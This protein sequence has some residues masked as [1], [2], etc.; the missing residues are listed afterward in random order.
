MPPGASGLLIS[1]ARNCPPCPVLYIIRE[2]TAG[3]ELYTSG[4]PL[5]T[6]AHYAL[7]QHSYPGLLATEWNQIWTLWNILPTRGGGLPYPQ[8]LARFHGTRGSPLSLTPWLP[9]KPPGINQ[10]NTN[11]SS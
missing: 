7:G 2:A 6:A 10:V 8:S 9:R 5:Y 3:C 11:G 1:D 4:N